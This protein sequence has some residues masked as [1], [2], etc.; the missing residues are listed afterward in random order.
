[1]VTNLVR[2]NLP[3]LAYVEFKPEE[4]SKNYPTM[5]FLGGFLS[6]MSGTKAL[7][8]ESK[9][10]EIGQ[11][12]IRFDYSGH[13]ISEGKFIDGCIESWTQD[14]LDIIDNL[15]VGKVMLVGSSMGGWISLLLALN[16]PDKVHS[17]IGLAAAP[18]FTK[19]MEERMNDSQRSM[20]KKQG[21][22]ELE[23]D[24]SD[25]NY[26]IT[27]KLIED[28]RNQFV[29]DKDINISVPVR[30]IQGKKDVDVNWHTAEKIKNKITGD[31]VKLILLDQADHRLSAPKELDILYKTV[32]SLL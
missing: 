31:N 26:I 5:L 7:F 23:N 19:T 22:F 2:E 6:D 29:L 3:N 21:Y 8:L 10:K 14:A 15:I 11:P 25:D 16:I 28:G 27:K 13:G 30:L 4:N 32:C 17:I 1:M 9:C 12:F 20:L 18:D 24:Y